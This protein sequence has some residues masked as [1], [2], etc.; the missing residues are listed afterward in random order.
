MLELIG[1]IFI[2]Q[3]EWENT[4]FSAVR[5]YSLFAAQSLV[6]MGHSGFLKFDQVAPIAAADGQ[7]VL[8]THLIEG[9]TVS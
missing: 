5:V 9:K 3:G 8:V 6:K 4:A 1:F 2:T 7:S